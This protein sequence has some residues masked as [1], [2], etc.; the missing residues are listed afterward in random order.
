MGL[1][2]VACYRR[3]QVVLSRS[4]LTSILAL[5]DMA[6]CN[7]VSYIAVLTTLANQ[8]DARALVRLLVADRLVAC[9]TIVENVLSIYR[10]QGNLEESK[11]ALVVLK[12]RQDRWEE[13]KSAVRELHPYE[14]PELIALPVNDGL[15]AYTGWLSEQTKQESL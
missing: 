11:E 10:W 5:A 8:D 2:V 6:K 14:V 15:P 9:G 12:T 4:L 3:L 13:L 7:E 1:L